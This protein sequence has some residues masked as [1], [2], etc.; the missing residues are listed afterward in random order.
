[1]T[2]V[3]CVAYSVRRYSTDG[4]ERRER[5]R[6]GCGRVGRTHSQGV[7]FWL[8]TAKCVVVLVLQSFSFLFSFSFMKISLV[9]HVVIGVTIVLIRSLAAIDDLQGYA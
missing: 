8:D 1:M 6:L 5:C 4:T 2:L 7:Q 3:V 9:W